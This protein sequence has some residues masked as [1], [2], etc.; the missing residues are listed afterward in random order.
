MKAMK[1]SRHQRISPNAA[2]RR[3]GSRAAWCTAI[4]GAICFA[5]VVMTASA[6]APATAPADDYP[7][8]AISDGRV[9][10]HMYLPDPQRGFYRGPRFDWSGMI[11]RVEYQGHTWF[12]RWKTSHN[13]TRHDDVVGPAEEF[14]MQMPLGYAEAAPGETFI[15]IGVGHLRKPAD[16]EYFFA[17]GY[18]IAAPGAWHVESGARRVL[19]R[20]TVADD[21][22]WGYV[23]VKQVSLL[24]EASGF[25]IRH[26][27]KNTGTK[28]IDTDVYC[29]NFIIIDGRPIGP[30]YIVEFPFTPTVTTDKHLHGLVEIAGREIRLKADLGGRTIWAPLDGYR[31][32]DDNSVTVRNTAGG[33]G[34]RITGDRPPLRWVLY[35]ARLA[36]CP[37]PFVAVRIAPGETMTWSSRYVL[38]VDKR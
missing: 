21:R 33:A 10:V 12:G 19:F 23:Y 28:A 15:K 8:V 14:G 11:S 25:E 22:G 36:L 30:E 7:S 35:G 3:P 4:F 17:Q 5:S 29:H 26:E 27:L 1:R 24:S 16:A 32:V 13:P 20:Q 37:E 9:T 38:L 31:G 6:A 18:E 34:I 2:G